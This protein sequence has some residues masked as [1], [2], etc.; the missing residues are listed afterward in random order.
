MYILECKS[1]HNLSFF[2]IFMGKY[3]I[4]YINYGNYILIRP[5]VT[6]IT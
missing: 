5:Q 3:A 2:Q 4:L 1:R 6:K